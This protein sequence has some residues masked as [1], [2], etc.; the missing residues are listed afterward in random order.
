M[1]IYLYQEIS[2]LLF[3]FHHVPNSVHCNISTI[4]KHSSNGYSYTIKSCQNIQFFSSLTKQFFLK[5]IIFKLAYTTEGL[6]GG[7]ENVECF[8]YVISMYNFNKTFKL[9]I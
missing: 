9:I 7:R 4:F 3:R 8:S 5:I 1:Y 2:L 6:T